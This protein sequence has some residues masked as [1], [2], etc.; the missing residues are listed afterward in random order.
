MLG[1]ARGD[2]RAVIA[3]RARRRSVCVRGAVR[4]A[5]TRLPHGARAPLVIDQFEEVFTL[6]TDV[7]ER[8]QFIAALVAGARTDIAAATVVIALRADFYGH[9][10]AYPELRQLV[11]ANTCLLGPMDPPSSWLRSRGRRTSRDCGSNRG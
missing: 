8:R 5:L 9:C 7:E 3:R 6:C 4:N 2:H 1:A 10:A 11:E